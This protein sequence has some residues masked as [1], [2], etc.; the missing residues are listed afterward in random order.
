MRK[1]FAAD[2]AVLRSESKLVLF[3]PALYMIIGVGSEFFRIFSA[4]LM[5]TLVINAMSY[6]ERSGFERYLL[7][8]TVTRRDVVLAR[9]AEALGMTVIMLLLQLAA[10]SVVKL[11]IVVPLGLGDMVFVAS[12]VF[13]YVSVL[14][15]M[16]MKTNIEKGRVAYLISMGC[17]AGISSFISIDG[18]VPGILGVALP[19]LSLPALAVSCALSIRFY[20]KRQF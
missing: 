15:P 18:G 20:E 9:Y 7:L 13:L 11:S 10:S 4:I 12:V 1:V 2:F 3:L 6:N 17:A 8:L 5:V 14:F 16:L 19:I